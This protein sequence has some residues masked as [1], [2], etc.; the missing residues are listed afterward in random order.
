MNDTE[1]NKY[2]LLA[3]LNDLRIQ[4]TQ[5]RN[6]VENS[7][8]MMFRMLLPD[9]K[10]DYVSPAST[11]MTGYTPEELYKSPLLIKE[12][13]HPDWQDYFE[14]QWACMLSGEM[15]LSYEYLIIHKSGDTRWIYQRNVLVCDK[16]GTPIAIE[17]IA[18]D[19]TERKRVEEALEKRVM[20][21]TRP[22]DEAGGLAFED[23][24][25]LD[26]IQ[27]LQD[28]FAEATGVA[29]LL[30]NTDGIPITRGSNFCRLCNEII[31][32]T[33]KGRA[34]CKI[35]DTAM[36][37]FN[38]DGPTV[39][40][41]LSAGLGNAGAAISVGGRHIANWMI[42]Q[43]RDETQTEEQMR[44]Y[45][46]EI[47]ADEGAC[48]A[49][50]REV[51]VMSRKQFGKIARVLFTL[52][53]QLSTMAFQNV[54]QA[55]FIAERTQ[56]EEA[57]RFS[58][59]KYRLLTEN[60]QDIV[61]SIDTKGVVN[62]ISPQ[63][64]LYGYKQ[65]EITSRN[66][67]EF[68]FP[69]D[70]ERVH[71]DFE[72]TLSTGEEFPTQFRL[73]N[74]INDSVCWLEDLGRLHYNKSGEVTGVI[75]VLRDIT[76]SRKA[77]EAL[78]ESEERYRL[79][80]ET[81][82]DII[83]VHNREGE[84]TYMNKAGMAFTGL[85]GNA[86]IGRSVADLVTEK[87]L[88]TVRNLLSDRFHGN[89][90]TYL[91]EIEAKS[92]IGQIV[93]F[94]VSSSPIVVNGEMTGVLV[95]ARDISER[96]RAETERIKLE[97]QLRHSQ[98]ME[99]IGQL[100]GGVA[101]DFNNLLTVIVG[102]SE[103]ALMSLNPEEGLYKDI[104]EIKT[105]A[106]RAAKITRQLLAFSRKEIVSPKVLNLNE[107]I[108]A[109]EKIL[110]RLIGEDIH[111]STQLADNLWNIQID[112]SQ[113]DQ[114]LMNFSVNAR[115][116]IEGVGTITIETR[117]IT[118]DEEYFENKLFAIPGDYVVMLFS[119]SGSGMDAETKDKA[120]EPFFSTKE[121]GKGTG[122]GLSTVFGIVKQNDGIINVYS[123]PG[124]GTTFTVYFPRFFGEYVLDTRKKTENTLHGDETVMIVEDERNI[125]NLVKKVLT[126][127]G[128]N[129][130]ACNTPSEAIVQAEDYEEDIHLLLA[131]VVMPT[132]NGK[133]L[134]G[135][136]E[137]L[138]SE[139]KT[140]FMSGY[141]ANVI[142]HRG[143]IDRGVNF[144]QKP[145]NMKSLA[146]KIREVLDS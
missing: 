61:V 123:E 26:D 94:E 13:I 117:N 62:Y 32:A 54:Q 46:R 1:K 77:N 25:N 69:E 18:T 23:L 3:E 132:M 113:I 10:V 47:G 121:N 73:Q 60:I 143:I 97:T 124:M 19:I 91:V 20:A 128:Y 17:G 106:D 118:L 112:P 64:K 99:A 108:R 49:A 11:D 39:Q 139:I 16:S 126:G 130:I 29:A 86:F 136:I 43:V 133:E 145:F 55:R 107:I 38:P 14:K 71:R 142:A 102:N 138:K 134:Q 101:H 56:A 129:V 12:I 28:E 109:R 22:L 78:H 80:A 5:L 58:E 75:T 34:N 15:P 103:L 87:H 44:E 144:I 53:N 51:P 31:R 67:M 30:T 93:P 24:F 88:E 105:T 42:G 146:E 68:I 7:K 37:R 59:E 21:L 9:G 115:D 66:F 65:E 110:G 6:L 122:L 140:V 96:K 79:L 76:E 89:T 2:Q 52:A 81:A 131:D 8:D 40:P 74:K 72:K 116:A 48:A 114:I 35:S 41:C 127:Y 4:N 95:V 33:D 90:D 137:S 85:Y 82:H 45:A 120:F 57:L 83:L 135:I 98:K 119:D 100:A 125:L 111:I 36:G 27:R 70:R 50:F 63:V 104:L 141:P 92:A 84:I